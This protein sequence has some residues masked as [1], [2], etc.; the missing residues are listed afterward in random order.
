MNAKAFWEG[1]GISPDTFAANLNSILAK[2][3]I[4]KQE[5]AIIVG[6]RQQ[7][8]WICSRYAQSSLYFPKFSQ[9]N[10]EQHLNNFDKVMS[11]ESSKWLLY[12]K[13]R[14]ALLQV[15]STSNLYFLPIETLSQ[16]S[17]SCLNQLG[18]WIE[19]IGNAQ[20]AIKG[21]NESLSNADKRNRLSLG[22]G[23]WML[24]NENGLL[25]VSETSLERIDNYFRDSNASFMAASGINLMQLGYTCKTLD[26]SLN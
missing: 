2:A 13:T 24:R 1:K 3:G 5:I 7:S 11:S 12:D 6:I 18:C 19:S 4:N 26:N 20:L 8:Q 23:M 21:Q 10:F 15:C 14:N 9:A 17:S 16:D 25:S 22:K